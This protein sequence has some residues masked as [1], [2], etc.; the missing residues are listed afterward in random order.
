[1][2]A[3]ESGSSVATNI[4]P[5]TATISVTSNRTFAWA[6]QG[7]PFFK[8]YEIFQQ[9]TTNAVMAAMLFSDINDAS[10]PA[11]PANRETHKIKNTLE[12]FSTGGMHG[13]VWRCAFT[14]DSVGLPSVLIHFLG[15]PTLFLPVFYGLL[16]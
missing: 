5:S 3:F 13:G 16:S 6:Y 1:M 10:S 8:P 12:L 2:I 11:H 15:G 14:I 7:M 4:A 9:E